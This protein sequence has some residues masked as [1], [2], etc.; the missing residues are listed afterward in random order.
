MDLFD[1]DIREII[2]TYFENRY[3]KLRII[4]EKVIGKCRCDFMM[5]TPDTIFG[6]EIKSDHDSYTRL[7]SQVKAYDRFFDFNYCVVG[8]SHRKGVFD[9]LPEHWG[10]I[11]VDREG[12]VSVLREPAPRKRSL[13]KNQLSF[14][15]RN[16]L[17]N[18]LRRNKMPKYSQKSK[19]FIISKLM[20]KLDAQKL[21]EELCEEIFERD[22]TLINEY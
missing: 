17:H 4:E 18:I 12:E 9:K 22:Y 14:L 21:K 3:E 8:E 7:G 5:L 11:L 1:A 16:E 15:W 10:V 13:L 20:E 19:K 2:F 6:G